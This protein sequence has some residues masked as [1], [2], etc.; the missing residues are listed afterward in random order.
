MK[1]LFQRLDGQS[2]HGRQSPVSGSP[3]A[4]S[5]SS[6][7]PS[8]VKDF[9]GKSFSVNKH[10]VVVEDI[11]AEGGFALVFLVKVH[12]SPARLALKR[13]FVNNEQDLSVCRREIQVMSLVSDHKNCVTL[14]DSAIIPVSEDVHEVLVL[15][16]YCR[17]SVLSQMNE[18]LKDPSTALTEGSGLFDEEE[19]LRIFC[20]VC[21]AVSRLHHNKPNVIHRDLKVENILISD[22]G[23]YVLCDFGSSTIKNV[24]PATCSSIAEVEEEIKKYTTLAYRSPEMIDL[25]SGKSITVKSDIWAL[26]CLLYKICFFTTP[27]GESALAIQ[28]A[29][30]TIPDDSRYSKGLHALIRFM[31]EADPDLRPDI[32]QVSS[33]AFSLT[34]KS[35]PVDNYMSS[36]I[37]VLDQLPLPLTETECKNKKIQEQ[38]QIQEQRQLQAQQNLLEGTSVVPR[39]RPKAACHLASSTSNLPVLAPPTARTPTPSSE[40]LVPKSMT[41]SHSFTSGILHVDQITS[42][43]T[44]SAPGSKTSTP[45]LDST[46]PFV[47]KKSLESMNVTPSSSSSHRRNASDSSFEPPVSVSKHSSGTSMTALNSNDAAVSLNPFEQ[48]SEE[49]SFFA[50]EFDRIRKTSSNGRSLFLFSDAIIIVN[51]IFRWN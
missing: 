6:T 11:I 38:K 22:S 12:G 1:R 29:Q 16:D 49:D 18:K 7:D 34:G 17:G 51:H 15:M 21:Q 19:I 20:D 36:P 26:G 8:S 2:S 14:I 27:F 25:Y 42:N 4:P 30:F 5:S 46:N 35:N 40:L 50:S 47:E 41:T 13:L 45:A 10:V 3:A 44:S 32:F 24:H 43:L 28:N 31:L 33:V 37:P 48:P 9:I 39:Q 23:H